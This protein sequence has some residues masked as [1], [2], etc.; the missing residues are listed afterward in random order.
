MT[1]LSSGRMSY[2]VERIWKAA[3]V[4]CNILSW[5]LPGGNEESKKPSV[6]TSGVPGEIRMRYFLRTSRK[7][8]CPSRSAR[9]D[10]QGRPAATNT[11]DVDTIFLTI[12][13]TLRQPRRYIPRGGGTTRMTIK[14]PRVK[15]GV[16]ES[17]VSFNINQTRT[18]LCGGRLPNP[19]LKTKKILNHIPEMVYHLS[20]TVLQQQPI[21]DHCCQQHL[22]NSLQCCTIIVLNKNFP[23]H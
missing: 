16:T 5:Q 20:H 1:T 15:V 17:A 11:F 3:V 9:S 8:Y 4:G 19:S 18:K 13:T 23:C 10:K 22:R 12:K 7:R 14:R 2:E 21:N 6:S